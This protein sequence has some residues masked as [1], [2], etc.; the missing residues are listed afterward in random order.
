MHDSGLLAY[1][2][3]TKTVAVY[4]LPIQ[5]VQLFDRFSV[6]VLH[7]TCDDFAAIICIDCIKP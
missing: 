7:L 1:A 2:L 3:C 6:V 5:S 4:V